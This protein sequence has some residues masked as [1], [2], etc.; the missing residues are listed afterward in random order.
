MSLVFTVDE[1]SPALRR[2]TFPERILR[3]RADVAGEALVQALFA[4]VNE[5]PPGMMAAAA[6][7]PVS[8]WP[9]LCLL[10]GSS[11]RYSGLTGAAGM[12]KQ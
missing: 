12:T 5:S 10:A 6:V 8:G 11:A 2:G 4:S 1:P 7:E 3:R 9:T